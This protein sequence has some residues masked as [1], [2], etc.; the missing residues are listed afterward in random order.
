[1]PSTAKDRLQTI[2]ENYDQ[3]SD[4]E[5]HDL[6]KATTSEQVAEVQANAAAAKLAYFSAIAAALSNNGNDVEAAYRAAVAANADV[7]KAR[8]Q[9]ASIA[10]LLTKM[11]NATAKAS[12]LLKKA[13]A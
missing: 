2:E 10:E 8:E 9:A 13:K 11:G 7:K 12:D 5:A 1:M 3:A 4:N 6:S